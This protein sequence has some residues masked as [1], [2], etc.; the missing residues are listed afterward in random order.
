M[1]I[2]LNFRFQLSL[3]QRLTKHRYRYYYTHTAVLMILLATYHP[4][5]TCR[6]H[7]KLQLRLQPHSSSLRKYHHQERWWM[8]YRYLMQRAVK[9][10]NR[11]QLQTG[12]CV[13]YMY[14][15][16]HMCMCVH[17]WGRYVRE[18]ER[19]YGCMCVCVW[20]RER[21]RERERFDHQFYDIESH[22]S[23]RK[24]IFQ[25]TSLVKMS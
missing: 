16:V 11:F 24:T 22:H 10:K 20:E 21:E 8:M 17:A 6:L 7:P 3:L 25:K 12:N 19:M 5:F 15:C 9:K 1:P 2:P 18:R 23:Y 4:F 13:G 14:V